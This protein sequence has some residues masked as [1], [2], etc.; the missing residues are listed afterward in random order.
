MDT[1]DHD[2]LPDEPMECMDTP[3]HDD[4]ALKCRVRVNL[5]FAR[6]YAQTKSAGRWGSMPY[7][8]VVALV[9]LQVHDEDEHGFGTHCLPQ[10]GTIG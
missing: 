9:S 3:D 6:R 5:D 1:P 10:S 4:T 2:P 7:T 8:H